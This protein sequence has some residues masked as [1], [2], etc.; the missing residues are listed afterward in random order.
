[1]KEKQ[2]SYIMNSYFC[3]KK[4]CFKLRTVFI[5]KKPVCWP[6]STSTRKNLVYESLLD[7][8]T[9]NANRMFDITLISMSYF[10]FEAIYSKLNSY[11]SGLQSSRAFILWKADINKTAYLIK[12]LLPHFE[13]MIFNVNQPSPLYCF[14]SG[15]K[16]M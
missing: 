8:T 10:L 3:C 9:M 16:R 13:N 15:C 12:H 1:M 5:T 6:T 11:W 4:L 7:V 14:T 2:A